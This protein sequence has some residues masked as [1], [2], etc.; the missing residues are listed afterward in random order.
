MRK[1]LC[2]LMWQILVIFFSVNSYA[3]NISRQSY[4]GTLLAWTR[5]APAA[6]QTEE[7]ATT[8]KKKKTPATEVKPT[9]PSVESIQAP[10][11]IAPSTAQVAPRAEKPAVIKP[12]P[13]IKSRKGMQ[14]FEWV[15]GVGL[16][17]GG[18]VLG[19][20]TYSDGSS[21]NVYANSG[22][23]LN[24]GGMLE[25]GKNSNFSTQ[26]S[27]GYK[28]GGP[29][30]WSNDVNWSAIP[31]DIIEHY[32]FGDYRVGL[33]INYQI[34]PQLK[35]NLP[36]SSFITKYNNA[37]GFIVQFGWLPAKNNYS[38]NLRYTSTRFQQSDAPNAPLI[39]GNVVGVYTNYHF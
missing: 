17:Q 30:I 5:A 1:L 22:L 25:N 10:I 29:R 4:N 27:V 24:F 28:S 34:N 15:L 21:A 36:T 13:V 37:L 20:V 16:E 11:P 32:Q 39:N 18:E 2:S 35:V 7:P 31:V 9:A 23:V 12:S 26:V 6:T 3:E 14:S 8:V 19:Q 38:L 33:G